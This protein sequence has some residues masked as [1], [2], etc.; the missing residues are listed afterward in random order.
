MTST[1]SHSAR[2]LSQDLR[3][4]GYVTAALEQK[5]GMPSPPDPPP[6]R[7]STERALGAGQLASPKRMRV[8]HLRGGVQ[9]QNKD[10][11][12]L[13]LLVNGE[14]ACHGYLCQTLRYD[15]RCL[16]SSS[17]RPAPLLLDVPI[18]T[19]QDLSQLD[20]EVN[21]PIHQLLTGEDL[22]SALDQSMPPALV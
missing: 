12:L 3:L 4:Q 22:L 13:N 19:L 6:K 2:G 1:R 20:A 8:E 14:D 11:V 9:L 15:K 18:P 10:S 17:P 21:A 7:G 16:P 5:M